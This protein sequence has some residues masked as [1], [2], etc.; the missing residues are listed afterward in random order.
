MGLNG[1][2]AENGNN[3]IVGY[4]VVIHLAIIALYEFRLYSPSRTNSREFKRKLATSMASLRA[5]S[6]VP[7]TP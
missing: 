4:E 1:K 2:T 6:F 3:S 5:I 7:A